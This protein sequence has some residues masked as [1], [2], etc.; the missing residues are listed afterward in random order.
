MSKGCFINDDF[1][2]F[3]VADPSKMNEAGL[4]EQI[5][6]YAGK[7]GVRAVIFNMNASRAF[8][9]SKAF[10]P[11][12]KGVEY[13]ADGSVWFRGREVVDE[14]PEPPMKTMCKNAY[15]LHENF[16]NPM[17]F[18]YKYCHE[19][20]AEMWH[21]MR[22]NDCHWAPD[23]ELPQHA[24][25][26]YDHPEYQVAGYLRKYCYA[27]EIFPLN[28]WE[29][30]VRDHKMGLVKEYLSYECDGIEIDWLRALPVFR[31]GFAERGR[32]LMNGFVREIRRHAGE[33]AARWGHPVRIMMRVPGDPQTALLNGLDVQLWA[34]EGL[35]DILEP[36]VAYSFCPLE[37]WKQLLPGNIEILG[38][39]THCASSGSGG[40]MTAC[41]E[42]DF[43]IA[44]DLYRNGADSIYLFNHFWT[45]CGYENRSLQPVTYSI[46]GNRE[47]NNAQMRRHPFMPFPGERT[48][49]PLAW[50][51]SSVSFTVNAGEAAAG[52]K[53]R[54][55]IAGGSKMT[56]DVIVNGVKCEFLPDATLPSPL[57]SVPK[58]KERHFAV[59]AIPD[60]VLTDGA[61]G[62]DVIN[63]D[64]KDFELFWAEI[65]IDPATK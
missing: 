35:F 51:K 59:F 34:R 38:G 9:D 43:A 10:D 36:D 42:M 62:V 46:V 55:M 24:E 64:A 5:D 23:P 7:G 49:P 25:F 47:L 31:R 8:F 11:I 32:E 40:R 26:W 61:N 63:Q 30:D 20:G 13:R 60:G 44:S 48:L 33:A 4:R 29:K 50:A 37:L 58:G 65:D 6:F 12:W 2:A 54:V 3:F 1:G 45:G 57:P 22:M 52:R 28:F 19:L 39:I 41:C 17:A 18:R 15:L 27:W 21:G 16:G 56:A 14:L 53:A